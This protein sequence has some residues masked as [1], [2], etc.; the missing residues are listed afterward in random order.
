MTITVG[1][2]LFGAILIYGGW[3]NLSLWG[4]ARGDNTQAKTKAA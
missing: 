3:K 2:I 4:L 1:M